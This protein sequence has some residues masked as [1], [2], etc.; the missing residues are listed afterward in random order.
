[1]PAPAP[2][3][4]TAVS[5]RLAPRRRGPAAR[6]AIPALALALAACA[7]D[8]GASC[9]TEGPGAPSGGCDLVVQDRAECPSV[10][11]L[12]ANVCNAGHEC[13]YCDERGFWGSVE[14]LCPPCT[15]AGVDAP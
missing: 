11:S 14:T 13:C 2:A 8:D 12:C 7:S 5:T 10:E 4:A 3:P 1:M 6:L 9:P 15:D